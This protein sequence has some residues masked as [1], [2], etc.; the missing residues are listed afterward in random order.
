MFFVNQTLGGNVAENNAA[1]KKTEAP[2]AEVAPK[3]NKS[4]LIMM[5]LVAMNMLVVIGVGYIVYTSQKTKEKEVTV[6]D[7]VKGAHHDDKAKPPAD[8]LV[9]HIVKLEPFIVN[10]AESKGTKVFKVNM[11][12]E[13]ENAE[14]QDEVQKRIPQIRDIIIILLSSKNYRQ[15]STPA[16]KE[17]LKDEIRDTINTFLTRGKVIKVLFTE[18]LNT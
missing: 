5:G 18:F 4:S 16:G 6:D 15:I 1:E 2:G 9:G 3:S 17:E 10:L 8:E 14:V 11:E 12:L 7:Y 13:V